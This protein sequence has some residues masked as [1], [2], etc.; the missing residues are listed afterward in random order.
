MDFV[1][2]LAADDIVFELGAND[3][4]IAKEVTRPKI[5]NRHTFKCDAFAIAK[6]NDRIAICIISHLITQGGVIFDAIG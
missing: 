3:H 4:F 2:D 1:T 6:R 5:V